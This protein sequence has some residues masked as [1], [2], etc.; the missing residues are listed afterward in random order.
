MNAAIGRDLR[1]RSHAR[2]LETSWPR[3]KGEMTVANAEMTDETRQE[4]D[5]GEPRAASKPPGGLPPID[6]PTFLLSLSTSA[7][8]D[9]GESPRPD[10]SHNAD[11]ELAQETID[12]LELLEVKTAGNLTPDETHLLAE[13]LYD[14]RLRFV[15]AKK[16]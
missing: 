3:A 10:G 16:R 9:L 2:P 12:I 8:V 15:A 1:A 11:L 4:A 7:L 14:L 6:F 5:S 13:L